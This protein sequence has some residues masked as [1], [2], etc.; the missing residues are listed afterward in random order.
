M[1]EPGPVIVALDLDDADAALA[2]AGR[3]SPDRCRLKV[4]LELFTLAGSDLVRRLHGMGFEIFLDLKFHDIPNTVAA[5]CRQAASLGV[6]MLNV[7]ALGGLRMMQ[8]AREAVDGVARPPRLIAVTVLTSHDDADLARIGI[9]GNAGEE[10][11]RLAALAAEAGLD[12]VVCSAH[13]AT[14]LRDAHGGGFLLVTPGI[15][16]PG[17]AADD[18]SRIMTPAKAMQA[19]SDYLVIGRSITRAADPLAVIARIEQQIDES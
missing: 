7:H 9:A 5:A 14:A 8:V 4:G 18:Q 16:L 6:W 2:F 11:G 12:G 19:G 17:D 13:E 1:T 3:L 15:R 10:V